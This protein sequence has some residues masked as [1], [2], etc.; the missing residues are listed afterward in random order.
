MYYLSV[1]ACSLCLRSRSRVFA[2]RVFATAA[3]SR[4]RCSRLHCVRVCSVHGFV[5]FACVCGLRVCVHVFPR[6]RV[7]AFAPVSAPGFLNCSLCLHLCSHVFAF[8]FASTLCFCMWPSDSQQIPWASK[9]FVVCLIMLS[10]TFC[11]L[12]MLS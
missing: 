12:F 6:L 11:C 1:D 9:T 5:V 10:Q 7:F 8:V 4:L 3:R 2:P